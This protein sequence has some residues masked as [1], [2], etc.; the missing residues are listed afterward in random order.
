[1]NAE[2]AA[3]LLG[4][5]SKTVLRYIAKGTITATHR[6][7]QELE[8]TEDQVE[9]LRTVLAYGK[10]GQVSD[11]I[12]DMSGQIEALSERVRELEQKVKTLESSHVPT[13]SLQSQNKPLNYAVDKSDV[14]PQQSTQKRATIASSTTPGDL[15]IGTLSAYDFADILDIDR[16]HMKNYMRRGV[17]GETL[18]ITEKPHHSRVGYTLKFL[19]PPQQELA[20]ALLKRHG[21]IK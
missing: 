5:S 17:D 10:S 8:I 15:P 20:I 6:H 4:C 14:Q 7:A 3:R 21:K 13:E 9:K 12:Q 18:E 16:E 11:I 2:Q 19:T 1:M